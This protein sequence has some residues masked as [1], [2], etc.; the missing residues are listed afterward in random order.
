[1]PTFLNENTSPLTYSFDPLLFMSAG[2]GSAWWDFGDITTLFQNTAMTTPVTASGQQIAAVKD[3]GPN[4]YHLI[5]AT[6]GNRPIYTVSGASKFARFTAASVHHL[7]SAAD[8]DLALSDSH[9]FALFSCSAAT[10]YMRI[11]SLSQAG[12]VNDVNGSGC[13][14]V[15][16]GSSAQV[17]NIRGLT[18]NMDAVIAGSGNSPLDVYEWDIKGANSA[19]AFKG[20]TAGTKDTSHAAPNARTSGRAAIGVMMGSNAP[21][22][23]SPFAGDIY[24]IMN[25]SRDLLPAETL[26]IRDWFDANR[27]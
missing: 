16:T 11:L 24:S 7:A 3:K 14:G 27:Y 21:T 19:Q 6:A 15:M 26:A 22:A 2:D 18:A 17:F 5:Q 25:F 13:L 23:T 8:I 1:M 12:S 10:D 4:G 9:G 20:G